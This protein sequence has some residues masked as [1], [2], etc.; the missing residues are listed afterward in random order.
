MQRHA[1][2]AMNTEIELLA[3]TRD[4]GRAA[5]LFAEAEA[6]L[7]RHEATLTGFSEHSELAA[8][9]RAAGQSFAAS[10]LLFTTVGAALHAAARTGGL[11][12]PAVLDALR[13]A[14]YDRSFAVLPYSAPRTPPAAPGPILGAFRHVELAP[15]GRTITRPAGMHLDLGG[16][17]KG[18][19]VA[20]ALSLL[21]PLGNAL[22]NAGGDLRASG[23]LA[24]GDWLAGVQHPFEPGRDIA[25]VAVRDAA[26]ATSSIMRRRWRRDGVERHHLID[27]RTG[28]SAATDLAAATVLA[29]T[30]AEADVLAKTALL[31]GRTAG[32]AFVER[33]GALCLLVG[34]DG[35]IELSPGFPAIGGGGA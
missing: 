2:F 3:D 29:R 4:G 1:F 23:R 7:H 16:I 18:L 15:R 13:A 10:P 33:E 31:L 19:A 21:R 20:A 11:F 28:A 25:T 30:A 8:L 24:D 35:A 14:G 27:P 6:L 17:G 32:R 9:N 5:G 26:L 22:A 34:R 12:E